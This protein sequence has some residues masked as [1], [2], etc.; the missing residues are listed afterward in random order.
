LAGL[1]DVASSDPTSLSDFCNLHD[2]WAHPLRAV[3]PRP[4]GWPCSRRA[5]ASFATLSALSRGRRIPLVPPF[6]GPLGAAA[7]H[8]PLA[9]PAGRKARDEGSSRAP[10]CHRRTATQAWSACA[11]RGPA[12]GLRSRDVPRRTPFSRR[13]RVLFTVRPTSPAKGVSPAKGRWL[14]LPSR[15]LP[16]RVGH[17]SGWT[18]AFVSLARRA[19][20]SDEPSDV[21]TARIDE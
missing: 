10:D 4:S 20:S 21:G 12:G 16:L 7:S 6:G 15:C 1:P 18:G 17:G 11:A 9:R 14:A 5:P 13:P 2:P 8:G 3:D 19:P